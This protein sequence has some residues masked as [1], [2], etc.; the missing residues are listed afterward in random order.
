MALA[1]LSACGE[2]AGTAK[3]NEAAARSDLPAKPEKSCRAVT[4]IA[5][6]FGEQ[7]VTGFAQSNLDEVINR[8]KDQMAAEGS[9]GFTI[10][11]RGVKCEG[12]IDFGG[13]VGQ[14][15]KCR[16]SAQLCGKG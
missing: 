3:L 2:V 13:G 10:E 16:A 14:E 15:H 12:Y 11:A 4:A 6:G 5:T 9:K 7:N 8:A 1:G